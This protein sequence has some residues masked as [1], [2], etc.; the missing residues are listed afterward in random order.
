MIE[1]TAF[2]KSICDEQNPINYSKVVEYGN[3]YAGIIAN[4]HAKKIITNSVH[5]FHHEKFE[6]YETRRRKKR[7]R[8]CVDRYGVTDF[9]KNMNDSICPKVLAGMANRALDLIE[10][11]R[12]KGNDVVDLRQSVLQFFKVLRIRSELKVASMVRVATH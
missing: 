10:V 2:L 9:P 5:F 3:T 11:K 4:N 7:F 6:N 12:K 8:K 1:K